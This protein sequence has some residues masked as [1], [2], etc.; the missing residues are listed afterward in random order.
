ME[1]QPLSEL[2]QFSIINLDKPTGPT[3]FW[4]SQK[5]KSFLSLKKTAHFGTLDPMVTGVLPVALNRACKLNEVFMHR[6]KTY[7]GI[8][9][10]HED[11]SDQ[12]LNEAIQK[13]LGEITQLPPKRSRV[14][15]ANRQRTIHTFK[16]LERQNKDV[17]FESEVQAG[18][19]IRKLCHDIGLDIG[20]AHMLELRRTQAG[21]F[22]ETKN[23]VTLYD[24]EKA[25][26]ELEKGDETQLRKI[27]QPV[28]PIIKSLLETAQITPDA[29]PS[30]LNGKPLHEK[31][32]QTKEPKENTFALFHEEQF[33]G[34]YQ[35]TEDK[36]I[37]AR[38]TF[39]FN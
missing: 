29:K 8:L 7:V 31:D 20:G 34:I 39:V 32:L 36:E 9:R 12:Q 33:I 16:I 24:L 2:L 18:T 21:F 15:R 23:L 19:Y 13:H 28:E 5:V 17:L 10:L 30:L 4:T 27:L 22:D 6:N 3:S 37:L 25:T 26:Q 38:P 35:K 1:E 14:K 11:V